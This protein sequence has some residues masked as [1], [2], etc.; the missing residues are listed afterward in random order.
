MLSSHI[1][2]ISPQYAGRH[3]VMG[4]FNMRIGPLDGRTTEETQTLRHRGLS[5]L[6]WGTNM[7]PIHGRPEQ[8]AGF[9]TSRGP[10]SAELADLEAKLLPEQ[11]KKNGKGGIFGVS[12]IDYCLWSKAPIPRMSVDAVK[13]HG[14]WS[15]FAST[16]RPLS[17]LVSIDDAEVCKETAPQGQQP[18]RPTALP[19]CSQAYVRAAGSDAMKYLMSTDIKELLNACP[20][21]TSLQDYILQLVSDK[22]LTAM[23]AGRRTVPTSHAATLDRVRQALF[24]NRKGLL[25]RPK[26]PT[27]MSSRHPTG[28]PR[29]PSHVVDLLTAKRALGRAWRRAVLDGNATRISRLLPLLEEI[30]ATVKR[31]L[32][33]LNAQFSLRVQ[34][35]AEAQ[36][37]TDK[38]SLFNML[39]K[40]APNT[41]GLFGGFD[42]PDSPDGSS[43]AARFHSWAVGA[44][45]TKLDLPLPD[46]SHTCPT[47][48]QGPTGTWMDLVWKGDRCYVELQRQITPVEVYLVLFP[49]DKH[50]DVSQVQCF[51]NCQTCL[52]YKCELDNWNGN[53]FSPNSPSWSPSLRT[54]RAAGPDGLRAEFIRWIRPETDRFEHRMRISEILAVAFNACLD[55]QTVPELATQHT[56]VP[57]FKVPKPGQKG[58]PTDPNC[59]RFITVGNALAKALSLVLTAR[60]THWVVHHGVVGVEQ[61][62]F[63]PQHNCDWHVWTLTELIKSQWRQKQATYAL[64]I[65]LKKAYDR[66]HPAFL[67]EVLKRN[68]VPDKL[69]ALLQDWAGRR[70]TTVMVNGKPCVGAV[71]MWEGVGQ[72]D[73]M[74]PILFNLF[75]DSLAKALARTPGLEGVHMDHRHGGHGLTVKS[76]FYADDICVV[77][78]SPTQ[79]QLALRTV[80]DWCTVWGMEMGIGAS[81]TEAMAFPVPGSTPVV[82]PALVADSDTVV[83]WTS[84]YRYLGCLLSPTLDMRDMTTAM[85]RSLN[86]NNRRF[87]R[88][89]F[90]S[91]EAAPVLCLEIHR[92]GVMGAANYLLAILD[93]NQL[94]HKDIDVLAATVCSWTG[95]LP[96]NRSM[97]ADLQAAWGRFGPSIF[98]IARERIRFALQLLHNSTCRTIAG[99]LMSI[100]LHQ[101]PASRQQ[102]RSWWE[103]THSVLHSLGLEPSILA[104]NRV[105]VLYRDISAAAAVF[106]RPRGR[107]QFLNV[108]AT[109]VKGTSD[110][111][112]VRHGRPPNIEY[113]T[114]LRDAWGPPPES[115]ASCHL[116]ALHLAGSWRDDSLGHH[117]THTALSVLGP[118][119]SGNICSLVSD[120]TITGQSG[121][122]YLKTLSGLQNGRPGLL[123]RWFPNRDLIPLIPGV[124]RVDEDGLSADSSSGDE[125]DTIQP[126]S[127]Y[128]LASALNCP[129]RCPLCLTSPDSGLLGPWHVLLCCPHPEVAAARAPAIASATP[130]LSKII[131]QMSR[132]SINEARDTI[133]DAA[134]WQQHATFLRI[135]RDLS[136]LRTNCFRGEDRLSGDEKFILFRLL[137]AMPWS[138][139]STPAPNGTPDVPQPSAL[140]SLLGSLFDHSTAAHHRLRKLANS[141][142]RWAGR[143]SDGIC[144]AWATAVS[145]MMG[146][147]AGAPVGNTGRRQSRRH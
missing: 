124:Q 103:T 87:T 142:V 68:G 72:G 120:P 53:P 11:R 48:P 17:V 85:I 110:K 4:D 15:Q 81:K 1:H 131:D 35:E 121:A 141:W 145:S 84:S 55:S 42:I 116:L 99:R 143:H 127:S 133:G 146:I 27:S 77:A 94:P 52:R 6:L 62:G 75:I 90:V 63:M 47:P 129:S 73:P 51:P 7:S 115:P 136:P 113:C 91:T 66:V 112:A 9:F 135:L 60:L 88:C 82:L 98:T 18:E 13:C 71:H 134:A 41:P 114:Q 109:R 26:R 139:H 138:S 38:H 70:V 100:F 16:H 19:R 107:K 49:A 40:V 80:K 147:G 22:F 45:A 89:N 130:M 125:E 33:R 57:I 5:G 64:F 3:L 25:H 128:S 96:A 132:A 126:H 79:L 23:E 67:W 44:Y 58:D 14:T 140:V 34:Q 92:L 111:R 101:P 105:P 54:S 117:P 76:L 12:E 86:Y 123:L 74:S 36:R 10:V 28:A 37:C 59:Y 50:I 83:S 122:M 78:T 24:G 118:W 95:G 56:T 69:L 93:P 20:E 8:P 104:R 97:P 46:T 144:R 21:G 65:D 30:R 119:G 61:I 106:V 2:T 137:L 31:E 43:A 39:N 108:W 29:M 102:H 32:H